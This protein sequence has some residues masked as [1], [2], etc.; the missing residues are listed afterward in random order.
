[1]E[2]HM[3]GFSDDE[4]VDFNTDEMDWRPDRVQDAR[5]GVHGDLYLHDL[6]VAIVLERWVKTVRAEDVLT[7][8]SAE[9][10]VRA[11]E[12]VAAHLRQADYVPGNGDV[13]A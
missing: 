6:D 7:G 5:D 10:F 13:P 3:P 11:L 9:G 2:V 4:R 8:Q 1:M 12:E